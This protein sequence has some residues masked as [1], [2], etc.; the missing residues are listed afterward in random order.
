MGGRIQIV[1]P[2]VGDAVLHEWCAPTLREAKFTGTLVE[3][4]RLAYMAADAAAWLVGSLRQGMQPPGTST[5]W[6]RADPV[7]R[8][9]VDE[10]AA[11]RYVAEARVD[12]GPIVPYL[13][14]NSEFPMSWQVRALADA[15]AFDHLRQVAP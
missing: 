5:R 10:G 2:G 6:W 1:V 11:P 12:D 8:L 4:A 15:W 14:A 3:S 13:D 7:D 9:E